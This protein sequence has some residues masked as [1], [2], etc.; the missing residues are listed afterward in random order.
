MIPVIGAVGF[1]SRLFGGIVKKIKSNRQYKKAEKAQRK[2]EAL[3][4]ES[5]MQLKTVGGKLF[6]INSGT[7]S[8][9]QNQVFDS[10]VNN[11]ISNSQ[12]K[13]DPGEN[14][15]KKY[16]LIIGGIVLVLVLFK[17]IKK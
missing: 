6:D 9:A 15:L 12:V 2:A 7:L 13:A 1:V 17:L 14:L 3:A 11:S 10:P 4:S 5:V 8:E 16:G